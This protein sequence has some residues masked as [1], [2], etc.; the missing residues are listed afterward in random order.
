M[1]QLFNTRHQ[2]NKPIE[3]LIPEISRVATSS[4]FNLLWF[5][6]IYTQVKGKLPGTT[7]S[8]REV[9]RV[10]AT[11]AIEEFLHGR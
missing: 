8:S 11:V 10:G 7:A 5:I 1:A 9:I 3:F 6:P 4:A 2:T